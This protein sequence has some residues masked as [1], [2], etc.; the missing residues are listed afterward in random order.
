[1]DRFEL[2]E[3]LLGGSHSWVRNVS[4]PF[5]NCLRKYST[6]RW[7]ADTCDVVSVMN[8]WVWGKSLCGRVAATALTVGSPFSTLHVRRMQGI[9]YALND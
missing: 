9:F 3:V 6:A 1:M 5:Y 8:T 4:R 7:K 2:V